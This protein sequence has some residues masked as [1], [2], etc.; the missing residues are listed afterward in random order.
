MNIK[1]GSIHD[2]NENNKKMEV[3]KNPMVR[4][5]HQECFLLILD[6]TETNKERKENNMNDPKGQKN[7]KEQGRNDGI[8]YSL[9]DI[10]K[11]PKE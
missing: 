5:I 8:I 2:Q 7:T 6:L 4:L 3:V 10:I 9:Q 1:C 11:G